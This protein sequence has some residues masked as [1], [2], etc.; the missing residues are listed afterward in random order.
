MVVV[1]VVSQLTDHVMFMNDEVLLQLFV[2]RAEDIE[3]TQK[4]NLA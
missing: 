2:Y 3:D 4:F 1:V